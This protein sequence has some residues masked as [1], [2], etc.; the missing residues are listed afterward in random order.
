M[1]LVVWVCAAGVLACLGAAS[2][3]SSSS[4][5]PPAGLHA[6]VLR[7]DEPVP[8][9]HTYS[10]MPAFAWKPV[11]GATRYE[12][13]LA[14]SRTF[15]D[16]TAIY[17][18]A[19]LAAPVA[20]VPVQVPWMTGQPYAL[21]AHVRTWVGNRVSAW[22]APFGFDTAWRQVPAQ[23]AA[24]TGLVRWTPVDGATA[25]E[26]WFLNAPGTGG[27]RFTTLTNVADERE[28]WTFHPGAAATVRWRVRAVRTVRTAALGNGVPITVYGPYSPVFTSTNPAAAPGGPLAG[29]HVVSDVDSTPATPRANALTPGFAWT[30]AQGAGGVTTTSGLWRVYVFSDRGCVNRVMTGSIVGGPAWAPRDVDPL[31]LPGTSEDLASAAGGKALGFGAQENATMADATPVTP[32]ESTPVGASTAASATTGPAGSGGAAGGTAGSTDG[33]RAVTLPDNGWPQGRYWWTV[34]PVQ[35]VAD[36]GATDPSSASL[37]YVDLELPQDACAAG[38]VWP[39]GIQS[40]PVTTSSTTPLASG[41]VAATRVASAVT[42]VPGFQE[43]PLVTWRPAPGAASYEVQVSRKLYPWK[44]TWSQSTD[45]TSAVLPLTKRLVG[46]WYYRVRGR[47]PDLPAAAAAMAWSKPVAIR[48]TGDRFVVGR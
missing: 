45:A 20:S 9:S 1:K 13:Q 27:V 11:R 10:Q 3:W 8:A 46:T 29:A 34:V 37:R 24:P 15:A 32:S 14:T 33:P 31:A 43:L 12:L 39:F 30:G 41:L 42:R 7:S 6:F 19:R 48:I 44:T 23:L 26:L 17:D 36:A 21:W 25:Y 5:V 4:A 47:N 35:A 16:A 22:S 18:N 28:Y 2:S 40:A 38:Q